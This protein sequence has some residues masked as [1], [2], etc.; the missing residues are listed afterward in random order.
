MEA[1][2]FTLPTNDCQYRPAAANT[3]ME[4]TCAD[5]EGAE[6]S[7][8]SKPVTM[9]TKGDRASAPL[10]SSSDAMMTVN[11]HP[12]VHPASLDADQE[13]WTDV[14]SGSDSQGM[15]EDKIPPTVRG[16]APRPH[17]QPAGPLLPPL[18]PPCAPSPSCAISVR[19]ASRHCP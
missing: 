2:T 4:P 19:P 6:V 3:L 5:M 15:E 17:P 1:T 12:S 13:R 10:A 11:E 9:A 8:D 18:R 16:T 7:G 14:S